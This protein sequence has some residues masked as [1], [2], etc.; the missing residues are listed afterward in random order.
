M[1]VHMKH[2]IRAPDDVIATA[3]TAGYSFFFSCWTY[4]AL[5]WMSVKK[6]CF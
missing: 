2:G 3:T 4:V 1:P 5:I 6:H